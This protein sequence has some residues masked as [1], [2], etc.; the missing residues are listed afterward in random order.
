M[1]QGEVDDSIIDHKPIFGVSHRPEDLT[2]RRSRQPPRLPFTL[3]AGNSVLSAFGL[4]SSPAAAAQLSVRQR[5]A[6]SWHA[7]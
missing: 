6:L 3:V 2:N 1:N 4:A 7:K 5:R